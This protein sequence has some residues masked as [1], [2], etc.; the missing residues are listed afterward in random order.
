MKKQ[1]KNRVLWT[2]QAILAILFLFAGA[3]KWI[4]PVAEMTKQVPLPGALLR[5][6]GTAEILGAL[7]LI[8]PGLLKIAEFLTSLAAAGLMII[9]VGATV[10][11]I[12]TAGLAPATLP[13]LVGVLTALVVYA[14]MP[15]NEP[16]TMVRTVRPHATY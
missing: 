12:A 1:T 6:I 15:E 4:L 3:M 8:L 7:G 13:F 11:T 14:R 10:I 5:F 2:V 9:M 16:E